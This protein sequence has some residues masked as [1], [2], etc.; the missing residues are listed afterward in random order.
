MATIDYS[1]LPMGIR[2]TADLSRSDL[3]ALADWYVDRAMKVME[4]VRNGPDI[5]AVI[6]E[7]YLMFI[8]E[9]GGAL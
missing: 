8:D 7:S 5:C 1:A 4:D 3:R 6:I 9:N 2:R